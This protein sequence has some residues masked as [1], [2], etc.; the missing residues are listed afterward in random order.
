MCLSVQNVLT[1]EELHKLN[2]AEGT[3]LADQ[4]ALAVGQCFNSSN[5][6]NVET[7]IYSWSYHL[8]LNISIRKPFKILSCM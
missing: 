4:V 1:S 2:V 6:L 5:R 3:S 7:S 8:L